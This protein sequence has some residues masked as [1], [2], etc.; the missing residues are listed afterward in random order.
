QPAAD[1][2]AYRARMVPPAVLRDPAGGSEQADGGAG[3]GRRHR[4]AVRPALA[5]H[6]EGALHALP[7]DDPALLL[8]LHP[9]LPG[10]PRR[11][12]PAVP[13]R[14]P[15]QLRVAV[16]DLGALLLR[17]LLGDHPLDGAHRDTV[18]GAGIDL[19][20]GPVASRLRA[21]RRRGVA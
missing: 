9:G 19:R 4:D 17:L 10:D 11:L 21:D 2:A 8:H 16:A 5:R 18:A 1:A 6:L 7:P 20:A 12:G 3:H 14:G 13:R 15:Q